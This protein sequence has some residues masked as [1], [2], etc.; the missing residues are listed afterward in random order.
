MASEPGQ[1]AA[2]AKFVPL[3]SP[4]ERGCREDK[5]EL[6]KIARWNSPAA[7]RRDH[8]GAG[9][10]RAGRL[11][12][13]RDKVRV[14]AKG[15]SIALHPVEH[16][17]DV[18]DAVI[19]EEMTF[20]IQGWVRQKTEET[21]AIVERDDDDRSSARP[22]RRELAPVVVVGLAVDIAAAVDPDKDRKSAAAKPRR[23]DVEIKAV[24]GDA[25][26]RGKHA[27]CRHLRA[28]IGERRRIQRLLPV[29]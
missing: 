11:A 19:G 5:G 17:L 22:A 16:G 10:R 14:T 4:I 15:G 26:R 27:E 6:S 3:V 29:G 23:E 28:G 7:Q 13:E 21:Q 1:P 24:L 9:V 20:R 12:T 25:G 18:H 8:V 2:V